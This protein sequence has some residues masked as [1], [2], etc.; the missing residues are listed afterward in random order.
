[1]MTVERHE[2]RKMNAQGSSVELLNP[3]SSEYSVCRTWLLPG[4][5]KILSVNKH[6]DYPQRVF[7]VGDVILLDEGQETK[8]RTVRKLAA[9]ISHN[10]ANLTEL[11]SVVE[12]VLKNLNY[13]YTIKEFSHPSFV[14]SRCGQIMVDEKQIGFFG[15]IH[16]SVLENWKLEN[17]VIAFEVEVG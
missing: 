14:E 13:D 8:T 4:L 3:T 16:P 2:F 5:M 6:R 10:E 1:V 7:E 9:V 11:K 12:S 17:P 15:E